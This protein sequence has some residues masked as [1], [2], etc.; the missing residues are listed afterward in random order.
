MNATAASACR[1][2]FPSIAYPG[3]CVKCSLSH[4]DTERI[5]IRATEIPF[6]FFSAGEISWQQHESLVE[7]IDRI[8][9]T[10]FN[11]IRDNAFVGQQTVLAYFQES[12]LRQVEELLQQRHGLQLQQ[13]DKE[14]FQQTVDLA[15]LIQQ[16]KLK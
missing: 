14:I 11:K 4:Y 7:S 12:I 9:W 2:V 8:V 6:R 5:R 13:Q 10:T 3:K 15:Q 16:L 1:C